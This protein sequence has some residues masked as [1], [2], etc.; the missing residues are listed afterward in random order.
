[1]VA[2][3]AQGNY[4]VAWHSQ[5]QDGSQFGIYA[6]RY[7][8]TGAPLGGEFRV[9]TY[10]INNQILP[11]VAMDAAGDFVVAWESYGQ[12]GEGISYSNVYAQRYDAAGT[13]VGV[14]FR[15]NTFTTNSQAN[16][17]VAMDAV[18]NFVIAWQSLGQDGSQFGIYAQRYGA[19]GAPL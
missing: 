2:M 10:T 6:Q 4:V 9:N 7:N 8:A 15:V 1:S 16:P 13:A 12:D 11:E 19:A 14:E 17:A 5:D 3:D 18:G